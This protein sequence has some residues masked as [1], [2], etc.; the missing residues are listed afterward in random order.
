MVLVR[1]LELQ[2]P[3]NID[4]QGHIQY[5]YSKIQNIMVCGMSEASLPLVALNQYLLY[6]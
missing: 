4:L 5:S 2:V 3:H 6:L 1:K